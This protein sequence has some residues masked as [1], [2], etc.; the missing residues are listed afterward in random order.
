MRGYGRGGGVE[1][2][3]DISRV[4]YVTCKRSFSTDSRSNR[5]PEHKHDPAGL[6][7]TYT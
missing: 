2:R 7:N 4:P 3:T 6:E 1:R 5:K